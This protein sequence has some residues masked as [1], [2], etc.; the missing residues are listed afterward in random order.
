MN[1]GI[2]IALLALMLAA[3]VYLVP[4]PALTTEH[5]LYGACVALA[6][7]LAV[8]ALRQLRVDRVKEAYGQVDGPTAAIFRI[9]VLDLALW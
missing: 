1:Q 9:G 8:L 4:S 5:T 2:K 7:L 3:L 6:A